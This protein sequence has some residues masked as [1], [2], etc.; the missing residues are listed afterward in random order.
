MS[1]VSHELS[2]SGA[3]GGVSKR[4]LMHMQAVFSA[5]SDIRKGGDSMSIRY[6]FIR[7]AFI[8]QC[9]NATCDKNHLSLTRLMFSGAAYYATPM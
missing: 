5:L 7:K 9:D 3:G 1:H 8:T 2:L 6:I 4:R